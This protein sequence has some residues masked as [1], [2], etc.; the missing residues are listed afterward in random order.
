MDAKASKKKIKG[1]TKNLELAVFDKRGK[2]VEKVKLDEFVFDG[3]ISVALIHQAVTTYLANQR[4]GLAKVKTRG[5][6]RGGGRKP[7]RQKGTGRARVGSIR[8]PLWRGGGVTFG[9]QPRSYYKDLPK[10]MKAVALKSALNDKLQNDQI[11][12]L[13]DFKLDSH[14]TKELAKIMQNLK[15]EGKKVRVV[16]EKIED[17]SKLA[18]RNLEKVLLSKASDVHT[19]EVIDCKKLILTKGALVEVQERVKKCL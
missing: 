13:K 15:L 11:L 7:W 18:S 9:P 19:A 3:H 16:I 5:E 2:E 14:K 12:I 10:K 1:S 17:N 6:V 8:S 4:K